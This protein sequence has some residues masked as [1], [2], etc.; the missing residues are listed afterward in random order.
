MKFL[1]LVKRRLLFQDRDVFLEI[2]ARAQ[3]VNATRRAH[4]MDI[5]A[6]ATSLF[7]Y[8]QFYAAGRDKIPIKCLKGFAQ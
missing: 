5:T 1:A 8:A 3:R 4:F 7:I 2:G 6:C